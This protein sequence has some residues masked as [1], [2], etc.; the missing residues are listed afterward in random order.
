MTS[1]DVLKAQLRDFYARIDRQQ[2]MDA[3]DAV[4]TDDYQAHFP[5]APTVDRE[6]LKQ[7]GNGFFAACPGLRH[8]VETAICEGDMVAVRL[9]VEGV[10]SR[11]LQTPGGPI[12]PANRPFRL[13]TLNLFRFAGGKVAEQWVVFDMLDFLQQVGAMPAAP[14]A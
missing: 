3:L 12:P 5:G 4:T 9:V 11:P 2:S 1:I 7:I 8:V 10:H 13:H 6:G 14:V